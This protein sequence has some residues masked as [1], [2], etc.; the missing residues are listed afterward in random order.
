MKT[1]ISIALFGFLYLLPTVAQ[2]ADYSK[3]KS[4]AEQFYSSGSY[5]RANEIY[6][7]VDKASLPPAE[8]RWVEFRIA[9]TSW[10]AQAATETADTTKFDQA[11]KQLEELIRTNDK[12]DERDLVW[13]EAHESLGDFFWMRRNQVNW[14]GAWPHYQ[15]ALD[16]WAGRREINPARERYLKI[17]FKAA[18]PD[19]P[20]EYYFYTYYGNNIPLDILENALK[21]STSENERAHL[22]YL[23]AMTMRNTGD[24]E[25]RQSVPDEF[26]A[27]LKA[28]KQTDWYDDA[29]YHYAEWMNS[30]GVIRQL[31]DGQWQ[32]EADY[33]KALEL[34][35]RLTREFAKGQTRYYDQA[36]E[37]IKQITDPTISVAVSNI[38]LPDSELQCSVEARNI[39][40]VDFALYKIDL[41]EDVRFTKNLKEDEGEGD[42]E[43][44]IQKP[45]VA[46]R[47]PVKTW[48]RDLDAKGD[49]K[50]RTEEV[51]INGK[52][53]LG[54]YLLEA[55]S[56]S[57]SARD[58]VLIT[59]AALVLKSSA[60][61]ALVYFS[62]AVTGA[63]IA[64]A[65]VTLWESYYDNNKWHSRRMAQTTNSDG[66]TAFQLK[67]VSSSRNLYAAAASSNRQAFASGYA[68]G[69][70]PAGDA[71]RIYAFTDRPAYRP[72]ETVQW[73]F[74]ARRHGGGAYSTPANEIVEYQINDP[75]GTKVSEGKATLN[76]FGSAWGSLELSEQLPLGEYNI[77]FWDQGRKNAIGSAKLFR[78]EEYKLPEFK[79]AVTTPEEDG[80]KK[81]FRLGEKVEV[82]IQADYYFG[83]PVSNASVEV[84]VYQNPF[85][86]YWYPHRDYPWY[87]EDIDRQGRSYYGGQGSIIKRET[88]KTDATGKAVLT[89][90]SPRENYNQDF[91]YRIEA[92]VT[93]SSRR[94]IVSSDTVRVTRQRYYVYPR[95]AQNIYRPKDKVTVDIKALDANEQPVTTEGTVKVTR[96]YWWEIWLDPNGREV[97]GEELRSLREKSFPPALAKGQKP[98]QLKYRGYHHDDILTQKLKTDAEGSAQLNFIPER[99]G[100]YRI[101]WE[102]GLGSAKRDRFLPPI[103]AQT[104]VFV[105]TNASTE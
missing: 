12:D 9:D 10:R 85:Y 100:Y 101:A 2:Q 54:A 70:N 81:S 33:I 88:I 57:L 21:I 93:D 78:L 105:A 96:D 23:I 20:N 60:K 103:T 43:S 29:L 65:S 56:G 99:D 82:N 15:Q 19:L 28:G 1:I 87:Y 55:R 90:D 61:Q 52:L 16:W 63:P 30:N 3:L 94:E 92:R 35:R 71:W 77:Q 72:K 73:K 25:T 64:N 89:F 50:P 98:W 24:L 5:A 34:F 41:T 95:P 58:L 32:Q 4:D 80:R 62:N 59:D 13:A 48:S 44:W 68:G 75:R 69:N 66:L 91:E 39:R 14:G 40:H 104:T 37:Q 102:S 51:R 84:V 36:V 17:V 74:I 27:A 18:Q 22:H 6:A 97:K 42:V 86:H 26:E 79:V 47:V 31:D 8:V 76:S 38:F 83:G 53:P 46:G 11:Q 7:R 67:N 45:R 49:H